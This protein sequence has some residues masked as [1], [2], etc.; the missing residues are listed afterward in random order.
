MPD[1][2]QRIKDI[3]FE[4]SRTQKNKATNSHLGL[5]K[6]KIARLRSELIAEG[7][8]SG[9]KGEGFDCARSGHARVCLIGFPSVGKSSFLNAITDRKNVSEAAAYEFTTLTCIPGILKYK[10][11]MIQILD[12]PG[13]IEGAANGQG[14]GREVIAVARSADVV[15]MFM[16][17]LKYDTHQRLLT[18]ELRACGIR[19]NQ[20]APDVSFVEKKGGKGG[21]KITITCEQKSGLTEEIAFAMLKD[22]KIHCAHLVIRESITL[23]QLVDV[24]QGNRRYIPCLYIFNKIDN[25]TMEKVAELAAR[26]H[27]VVMSATHKWNFPFFKEK[28]WEYLNMTRVYTKAKGE[29]PDLSDPI[30]LRKGRTIKDVCMHIHKEFIHKFRGAKVWGKSAKHTPQQVGLSFLCEDEDVVEI[31]VKAS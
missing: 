24:I 17:A 4:M 6:G 8:K 21:V 9:P 3:E 29:A 22:Y 16:D 1:I 15:L 25:S 28:L 2:A 14:R 18:K 7:S 12:L 30:I 5:L 13:I 11:S 10:G 23:D 20:K 26:P 31:M 19:L 27:S